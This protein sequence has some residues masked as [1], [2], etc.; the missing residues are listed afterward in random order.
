MFKAPESGVTMAM[1]NLNSSIRDF[2]RASIE[3]RR[4]WKGSVI[5]SFVSP[6]LY[7]LAMGVLLGGY[8]DGDPEPARGRDVLP[9]LRRARAA[10][11]AGDDHRLR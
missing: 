2:A 11:R 3:H 8:V 4:T 1:Y 10:R 7:V 6:L 5:T 9:R